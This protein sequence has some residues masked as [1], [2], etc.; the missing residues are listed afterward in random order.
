MTV[1]KLAEEKEKVIA[2]CHLQKTKSVTVAKK[3]A[4]CFSANSKVV[5]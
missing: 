5:R 4:G 3:M 2:N 1:A